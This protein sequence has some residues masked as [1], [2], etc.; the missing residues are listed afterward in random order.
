[1]LCSELAAVAGSLGRHAEALA[2]FEAVRDVLARRAAA[3]PADAE[4]A[5]KLAQASSNVA[6]ALYGLGEFDRAADEYASYVTLLERRLAAAPHDATRQFERL[7]GAVSFPEML[8]KAGR[9][10]D[11][12]AECRTTL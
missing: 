9:L 6:R 2:G 1:S 10:E 3:R 11:A 5:R 7:R 8:I 12:I 4:A